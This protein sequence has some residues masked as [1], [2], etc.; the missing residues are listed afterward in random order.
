VVFELESASHHL[1]SSGIISPDPFR[2]I[3]NATV[4]FVST[5]G[6]ALDVFDDDLT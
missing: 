1:L 4:L 5:L 6:V 3:L 2:A